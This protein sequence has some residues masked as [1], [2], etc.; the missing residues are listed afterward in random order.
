MSKALQVSLTRSRVCELTT[1]YGTRHLIDLRDPENTFCMPLPGP[2][3]SAHDLDG[4]WQ[5]RV[6]GVGKSATIVSG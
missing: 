6:G 5:A 2:S 4:R 1:E 3:R